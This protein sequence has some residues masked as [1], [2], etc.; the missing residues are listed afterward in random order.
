MTIGRL[1]LGQKPGLD[2]VST[3]C[4]TRTEREGESMHSHSKDLPKMLLMIL[5]LHISTGCKNLNAKKKPRRT[6]NRLYHPE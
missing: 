5:G 3:T 4:Q 2:Y 6:Y 1:S